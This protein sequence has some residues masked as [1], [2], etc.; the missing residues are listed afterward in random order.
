MNRTFL[1]QDLR[2]RFI[3]VEVWFDGTLDDLMG[4]DGKKQ[5]ATNFYKRDIEELAQDAGK[6]EIEYLNLIEN[7]NQ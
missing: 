2:D 7:E 6:E 3:G 1:N 5:A 4:V